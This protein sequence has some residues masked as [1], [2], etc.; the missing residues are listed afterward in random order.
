LIGI[1]SGVAA[2]ILKT[3]VHG[4]QNFLQEDFYTEFAHFHV[5]HLP[6]N[7]CFSYF[8]IGKFTLKALGGHGIPDMLFMRYPEIQVLF[9]G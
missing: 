6:F 3:L 7:W 4:I 2:M 5:D 8:F 9:Q 1:F